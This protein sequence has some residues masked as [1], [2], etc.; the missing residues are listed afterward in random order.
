MPPIAS[1]MY[2]T[3]SCAVTA[4][5]LLPTPAPPTAMYD[6][7]VLV[8]EDAPAQGWPALCEQLQA[9]YGVNA[10]TGEVDYTHYTA[11]LAVPVTAACI[12]IQVRTAKWIVF[13]GEHSPRKVDG[14]WSLRVECSLH[15]L[16]VGHNCYY[17]PALLLPAV[18]SLL[19][20]LTSLL[21]C[22]MPAPDRWTIRRLDVAACFELGSE[23]QVCGW[24]RSRSLIKYPRREVH[25][26]GDSGFT[27]TG[28]TTVIRAYHKG[29]QLVGDETRR[30]RMVYAPADADAIIARAD[31]ILRCEVEIRS[32]VWDKSPATPV[33]L[34][35][36]WAHAQY[37]D[38]WRRFLRP[39]D[40]G[41]RLHSTATAVEQQLRQTHPDSWLHLYQVWCLLAIRGEQWYT[42]QVDART[43][44]RHRQLLTDAD[45]GWL[46]TDVVN[47]AQHDYQGFAP[48]LG[49]PERIP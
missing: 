8:T 43:W 14:L 42:Q 10:G 41:T 9:R 20:T 16:L 47:L 19:D 5:R 40:A 25:F 34:S 24:I 44:R 4:R 39:P 15:K 22:T 23:A 21:D 18:Q 45:V 28:S 29:R 7:I 1:A 32:Y 12:R 33:T 11:T 2:G 36:E 48:L 31:S 49:A 35:D 30:L 6:T 26:W 38:A 46:D 17:G 27:T 13:P 3:A 37:D